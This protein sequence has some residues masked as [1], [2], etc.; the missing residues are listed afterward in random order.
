MRMTRGDSEKWKFQRT[1]IDGNV[2]TST[3]FALFFTVKNSFND[4]DFV[5]QKRL[6]DGIVF[7]GE[8]YYL[9]LSPSDTEGLAYGTYVFDIEVIQD[10][11]QTYKKTI[12]KGQ[13]ILQGES[14]WAVNE[15]SE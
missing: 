5:L 1:D 2:I 14:T 3:P 12:K 9:S 10:A 8:Y 6:G 15:E 7:D 4:K 11:E 13:F